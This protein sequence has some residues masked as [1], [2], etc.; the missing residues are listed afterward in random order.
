MRF[1]LVRAWAAAATAILA[2]AA[3]DAVTEFAENNGWL[4]GTLRDGQHEA[5]VPALLLGASVALSLALYVLLARISPRD[6]LV[7]RL[8]DV[9][10]RLADLAC[11]FCGS[12][13]SVVAM[14]GYET[15]FGGVSP[16]DPRSVVV[17]HAPA[18]IVAFLVTGAIVHCALRCAIRTASRASV[19][20]EYFVQFLRRLFAVI[21]T[22]QTVAHSAFELR[23]L[24]VALGI[25]GGS[26]SLRAPPRST[27][28]HYLAI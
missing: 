17:S 19:V 26:H 27:R 8:N 22:P 16:F 14:E 12:A 23:C 20:V 9:R 25:A 18:L 3:A 13:L 28:P 21:C 15:R 6:L 7:V 24:R 5:M 2:A 11:G 1:A 10:V 4:G